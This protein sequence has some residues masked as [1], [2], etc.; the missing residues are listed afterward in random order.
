MTKFWRIALYEYKRHVLNK[1]FILA[2]L[3]VPLIGAL[4][5]GL[6]FLLVSLSNDY[7]PVGYVDHAGA[8]AAAIPPPDPTDFLEKP[9]EFMPFATEEEARA[10]LDDEEIQGYYILHADYAET[11]Q[12]TVVF[13]G[14]LGENVGGQ[15]RAFMRANLLDGYP[16]EIALRMS[17][18]AV[19][20]YR[21]LDGSREFGP[22]DW[23][24]IIFPILGGVAFM[25]IT[26]TT[27][28]YLMQAVTE[29]KENRTMEILITSV[30]PGQLIGGKVV[31]IISVG[32]T[33][34][35]SWIAIGLLAFGLGR[36]NV[37]FL[38]DLDIDPMALISLL[39]IL[40][41]AYVMISALLTAVGATVTEASEGQQITGM[42]T[43]PMMIPYYLL[44]QIMKSPNS[45][46]AR[47]MSYFPLTSPM[48]TLMRMGFT[49][50][51]AWEF[52]AIVSILV[53]S[54]VGAMW[55]AGRAFRLGMLRYGQ[56]VQW[57]EL[58]GRTKRT[59]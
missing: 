19:V 41:P 58:F 17:E 47:A 5:F 38:Q 21:S 59:A 40:V 7:T 46:L 25:I 13:R 52:A 2:V 15:F 6:I 8:L 28:G 4:M 32:L 29:E 9:L 48:T 51:P 33:Q 12:A 57:R 30:S 55:L 35:G 27:S 34:F 44:A 10:A 54:A 3:S 24:K 45:P 39:L 16:Q 14:D 56:K 31:G 1:R 18:G 53:L 43:V 42:L 20:T 26:F 37:E 50:L 36:N 11:N 23:V 22:N 49:E